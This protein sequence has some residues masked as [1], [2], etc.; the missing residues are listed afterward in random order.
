M[1]NSS[2]LILNEVT[3]L[4][5]TVLVLPKLHRTK[6]RNILPQTIFNLKL[7][8]VVHISTPAIAELGPAQP[9]LVL[10]SIKHT[11]V[12]SRYRALIYQILVHSDRVP[13]KRLG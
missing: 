12:I 9:Q 4:C 3:Q 7:L 13:L 5:T 11:M 10:E 1:I 2:R 6:F 8:E